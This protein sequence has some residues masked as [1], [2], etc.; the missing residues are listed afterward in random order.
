[1]EVA[2]RAIGF[3]DRRAWIEM[4]MALWPEDTPEVHAEA[5]DDLLNSD[6]GWGLIA[7]TPDRDIA[8]PRCLR[9]L[10]CSRLAVNSQLYDASFVIAQELPAILIFCAGVVPL[11]F[12]RFCSRGA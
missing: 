12:W 8:S 4:R 5:V 11:I 7:E 2:I 3:R 1:M 6:V 10:V 9:R